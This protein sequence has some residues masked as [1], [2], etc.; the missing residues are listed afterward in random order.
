MNRTV[1]GGDCVLAPRGQNQT[2]GVHT[3]VR[4]TWLEASGLLVLT[5][6]I[7]P[8]GGGHCP[9]GHA[10]VLERIYQEGCTATLS[11]ED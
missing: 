2:G 8:E 7:D 3:V 1:G 4:A 11:H 6:R 5:V 9:E 10:N